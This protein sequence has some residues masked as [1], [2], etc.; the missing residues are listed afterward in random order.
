[1]GTT[2]FTTP[3]GEGL[4]MLGLQKNV[5]RRGVA[6]ARSSSKIDFCFHAILNGIA[7]GYR[8][9]ATADNPWAQA[10]AANSRQ[11]SNDRK[12]FELIVASEQAQPAAR[13]AL[14]AQL[15][16]AESN[17]RRLA[18]PAARTRNVFRPTLSRRLPHL[19]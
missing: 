2:A 17:R 10:F 13:E 7:V 19:P 18:L 8:D 1:M 12:V 9:G 5:R 14:P 15:A 6:L 16:S 4:S 11:S 3:A